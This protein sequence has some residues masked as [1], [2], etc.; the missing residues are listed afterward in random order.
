M[1]LDDRI[2][3]FA[4]T[5]SLSPATRYEMQDHWVACDWNRKTDKAKCGKEKW[6]KTNSSKIEN[7]LEYFLRGFSLIW[8]GFVLLSCA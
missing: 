3:I 4:R 2:I 8:D 6:D 1:S 5:V 7:V